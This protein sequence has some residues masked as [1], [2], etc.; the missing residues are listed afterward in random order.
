[1]IREEDSAE[2]LKKIVVEKIYKRNRKSRDTTETG[3][4]KMERI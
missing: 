4:G 3:K 2:T 1:M